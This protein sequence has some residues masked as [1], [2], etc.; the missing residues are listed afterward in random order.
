MG[1]SRKR[2]EKTPDP[3]AVPQ[4]TQKFY[5]CR[6]GTAY[7]RQKGYF[8]VSHSPM[9]RRSGYLPW[10]AD[11]VD[12][13]FNDY[14]QTLGDAKAAMRRMCM[15]MDLYWNDSIFEMVERSAGVNSWVR[16][17]IGKTNIARFLDKSYDDT[18]KEESVSASAI[19]SVPG[20]S[21]SVAQINEDGVAQIT[22]EIVSF[23]GAG[24]TPDFYLDLER[25]YKEWTKG[26]DVAD[27]SARALYKQ[28]CLLEALITKDSALGKPVKD[29][30][31][32]LNT[33]LGS[34]NL[35]PSQK[36]EGDASMENT[37]FGV[38]IKR[39]ENER[40]VPDVDP[41]LNDVDGIVRYIDAWFRGHTASML[42]IKNNYSKIYEE[43]LAKYRVDKPEFADDDD[44]T[45]FDDIFASGSGSDSS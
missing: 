5:C 11:C 28:I 35:K 4:S 20:G 38:W 34:M 12:Q 41:E 22:P 29:N 25:R 27:P 40:P 42:G 16:S 3:T 10:C 15:K 9:Y 33:L 36:D 2:L 14:V 18:L 44:E 1:S 45:P 31:N 23:W 13:M 43:E 19:T 26:E 24:Y 6:C 17:Y 8:P 21:I 37:P 39:W 32:T 7:S 30:I